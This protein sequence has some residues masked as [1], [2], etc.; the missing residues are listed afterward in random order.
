MRR[1]MGSSWFRT[2]HETPA[3]QV[4]TIMN[5]CYYQQQLSQLHFPKETGAQLWH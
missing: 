1:C 4:G 3:R 2:R 5:L